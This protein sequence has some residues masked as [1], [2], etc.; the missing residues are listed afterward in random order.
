MRN[1]TMVEKIEVVHLIKSYDDKYRKYP[2]VP[3]VKY[4]VLPKLGPSTKKFIS[5]NNMTYGYHKTPNLQVNGEPAHEG[6]LDPS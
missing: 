2:E 5:Y 1:F 6:R 4:L 3:R